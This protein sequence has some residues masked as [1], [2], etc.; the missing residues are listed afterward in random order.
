[1]RLVILVSFLLCGVASATWKPEYGKSPVPVQEWFK[2]APLTEA[3]TH[4]FP[5]YKCC[6]Q[7]ER[8]MT[9]FVGKQGGEWSYY[10]DPTCTNS[11]CPLLPIPDYIIHNDPIQALDHK[12]DSLPEFEEMR[13]EGVLFIFQGKPTCFWPPE[14]SI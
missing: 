1:M 14:P 7:A 6:E 4:H 3:A 13:R 11:G 5:F 12:D 10:P 8:L 2:A 9:K